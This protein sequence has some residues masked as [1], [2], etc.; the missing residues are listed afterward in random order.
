MKLL[1]TGKTGQLGSALIE[2]ATDL[3]YDIIAPSRQEF[4]IYDN[5]TFKLLIERY[6]PRFVINTA[7]FTNVP[8]CETDPV[9]AFQT[10]CVAV[11]NMAEI[12]YNSDI[13]F[14]TF[15]TDYVFNGKKNS[16]YIE[17]DTACPIQMYGTTKLAG[18]YLSL[19]YPTTTIIR[20]CG[21]YGLHSKSTKDGRGN[22]IDNRISDSKKCDTIEIGTDQTVSPT[23]TDDLSKA[24]LEL[25]KYPSIQGIYH[26][27]NEGQCT[28]YELTKEIFN[29]LNINCKVIP[30]DRGGN[31][32]GIRKPIFSVLRNERALEEYNIRLPHW[33]YA[34]KR[35]IEL[36]YR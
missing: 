17:S 16:P 21:L 34:L 2:Y 10:N 7:A 6:D 36:K 24:T 3:G 19:L 1:L 29:I 25:I 14:I 35:Y 9:K 15:S 11:K 18:E 4:D 20:T 5:V 22:F 31:F 13:K 33:I 26:L 28:W 12:C 27:I 8:Q 32:G 23:F 30:I